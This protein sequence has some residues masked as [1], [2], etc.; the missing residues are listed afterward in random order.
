[1]YE[2]Q[3]FKLVEEKQFNFNSHKWGM[4][5]LSVNNISFNN[6]GNKIAISVGGYGDE[7][8]PIIYIYSTI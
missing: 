2:T 4:T 6:S 1:L 3:T 7:Y 8:L 5:E